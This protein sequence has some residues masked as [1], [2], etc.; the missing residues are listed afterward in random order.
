MPFLTPTGCEMLAELAHGERP[1]P[2]ERV[3]LTKKHTYLAT[4]G[5][6]T[7]TATVLPSNAT[8]Q[9]VEWNTHDKSVV[10]VIGGAVIGRSAGIT[11][12]TVTTK[13]GNKTDACTV[14]V[15]PTSV[16]VEDISLKE[17]TTL[18]VNGMEIVSPVI[19]PDNATNQN[20]TWTSSNPTVAT[21]SPAGIITT[22]AAGTATVTVT[23]ADGGHTTTLGVIVGNASSVAVSGVSLNRNSATIDVGGALTLSET[24]TPSNAANKSV[25]WS[26]SN[27]A[28]ATVTQS[29]LVVGN[30]AGSAAITVTTGE[31][32]KTAACSV[33]V[34]AVSG[35]PVSVTGVSLNRTSANI[36][37]GGMETLTAIISPSNATNKN[38]S[39]TSSNTKIARVSD[40]GVVSAVSDGAA[41]ITAVTADGNRTAACAVT[42]SGAAVPVTGVTLKAS[43]SLSV[44]GSETLYAN[45]LPSNATNKSVTWSSDNSSVATVS[46][47]GVVY[48]SSAGSAVITVTTV[49][50]GFAAYCNVSVSAVIGPNQ[51]PVASDY[52]I[53]GLSQVYNGQPRVV[54]ITPK[55]GK[56]PGAVV[57][58]Y[59]GSTTAPSDV[60]NYTITFDVLPA[61]GWNGASAIP[62]GTLVI[63][64]SEIAVTFNNVTANGSSSQ[65]STQ[66]T[67]TFSAAINGLTASDI[68]L[69]GVSG[70]V[71]GALSGSNPYTLAISG[72]TTG[73]NVSVA[74]SKEGYAISGTPKTVSIY[75][76]APIIEVTF[77]SVTADGS[78]SQTSTQLTLT[79]SA[80]ITGLT[81]ADISL[82][83]VSGVVKG[84][85]SG[86]NPYT[87][88][89]SGFTASGTLSVSVA[90]AGYAI[91]GGPKT[92][93]IYYVA[94]T[95]EVTFNSVTADGSLSQT[96]TQLAL[97]F[98]APIAGL[99]ADDIT[100][101]GV[102]GVVKGALS[103]SNPYTLGISGFTAS[104][105]LT[106]AVA[107][108]GYNISGMPKT[109]SIYYV[110]LITPTNFATYLAS[111]P[112][113]TTSEPYSINLKIT[114]EDELTKVQLAFGEPI[115]YVYLDLSGSTIDSIDLWTFYGHSGLTGIIISN[116]ITSIEGNA[117]YSC[118][119][120]KSVTLP[121]S[122]N[123]IEKSTFGAC[124]SLI[125]INIPD[126]VTSIGDFAFSSCS[127][128]VSITIPNIRKIAGLS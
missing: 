97:T 11:F 34:R 65:I 42:V 45:V 16:P 71:K 5:V 122:I 63:S 99:T 75:Y 119:N 73:G 124:T 31:G 10:D 23:T 125:N 114:S 15:S 111:L 19:T 13:D 90:K 127:S 53:T 118:K 86:S 95:I 93:S 128:L 1:I 74:V 112:I 98:S 22:N 68:T 81:A 41:T 56:S 24:V 35:G 76:V 39:W 102:S 84:A 115:K 28:V 30:A 89:I 50:G 12:I 70:V 87:L 26:S 38:V 58:Y 9:E 49:D 21:V 100:L 96:S 67:L 37:A 44:G 27:P 18:P 62:G 77:N 40:S 78:L 60:G 105:S 113:N 110:A 59:N 8:N 108:T 80:A 29:G 52:D 54:S 120:L 61:T 126:S 47:S 51:N 4:G 57:V 123:K 48:A 32:G 20:V 103:G 83:G 104:G 94:P 117:F 101:S 82:S 64:S 88:A 6:E 79:F 33:T 43:T 72:F 69:S 106:V 3:I 46:G 2:V 36:L 92:V 17:N 14:T 85:L 121:S 66:L 116:S 7:F 109:V 55:A 91:S 25:L 107:K